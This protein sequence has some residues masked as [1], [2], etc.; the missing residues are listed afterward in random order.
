M[1]PA[2]GTMYHSFR[3]WTA[4]GRS[5]LS[6]LFHL[7]PLHNFLV[8]FMSLLV[9]IG[10]HVRSL[11]LNEV[12]YHELPKSLVPGHVV[13]RL[14]IASTDMALVFMPAVD[15]RR[16]WNLATVQGEHYR[17]LEPCTLPSGLVPFGNTSYF[18]NHVPFLLVW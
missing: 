15:P 6:L 1:Y 13:K 11:Y 3:F 9:F 8:S 12:W 7:F 4:S 14:Y 16:R 18:P 10:L 2:F 5:G 17:V